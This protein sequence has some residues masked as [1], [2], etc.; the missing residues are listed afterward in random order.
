MELTKGLKALREEKCA[1]IKE[2]AIRT[3]YRKCFGSTWETTLSMEA[4]GTAFVITGDIEAMWLRDSSMQVLPYLDG[5]GEDEVW[6]MFR[7]LIRRQAGQICTDPY[8]NAFNKTGDY[9]C[10]EKDDTEMGPYIWERKY[11]V[12]SLAF[13]LYLLEK[14]WEKAKEVR[15]EEAADL[16]DSLVEQAVE[17]ILDVW[18]T[19]QRHE[20]SPY[21]FQRDSELET[22]TLQNGGRGR[23]T[24]YTGMTWSGF[25]PSD[26]ACYYNYLIPSNILALSVLEGLQGLPLQKEMLQ[27]AEFLAEEIRKGIET[28]GMVEHPVYGK[29]FVYETDG[30][31]NYRL[32][33]D[34]N[35]PSLL[36]IPL[37]PMQEEWK[38]IYRNTRRFLL[39]ADNPY[40][41]QGSFAKGIGSPHTPKDHVWPIALCVQGM[42][43]EDVR[44]QEEIMRLL[45]STTAGTDLM[46]ESF[47]VEDP[48]KFTRDWFAWA[49]SMFCLFADRLGKMAEV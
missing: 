40:Y 12:D 30:L 19:E 3:V 43:S 31:G 32:M 16:V 20:S 33:D 49:N 37:L 15:Q 47:H 24:G 1:G 41:Y 26:D 36:G 9:R 6:H 44:E 4:D 48:S 8:A 28:Y 39:S 35:L 42:T 23:D 14:V 34:A 10:W 17:R 7:G 27:K 25:R 21:S 13:P 46:H 11:E 18:K 38:E 5:I 45:L 29:I 2:E 22:E